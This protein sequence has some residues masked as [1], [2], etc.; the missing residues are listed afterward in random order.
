MGC[1]MTPYEEKLKDLQNQIKS[2]DESFSHLGKIS[3]L[4]KKYEKSK[5]KTIK[6]NL[7]NFK[8]LMDEL[9]KKSNEALQTFSIYNK[10]LKQK[11]EQEE[12]ENIKKTYN[13]KSNALITEL[14]TNKKELMNSKLLIEYP[15]FK[16]ND[17]TKQSIGNSQISDAISYLNHS[18]SISDI[19]LEIKNSIYVNRIDYAS[20][21]I[22]TIL[23]RPEDLS[24]QKAMELREKVIELRYELYDASEHKEIETSLEDHELLIQ[25]VE[26][27]SEAVKEG[28]FYYLPKSIVEDYSQEMIDKN[29]DVINHNMTNYWT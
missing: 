4:F 28:Y 9:R 15:L 18:H 19:I 23:S 25:E 10:D 26:E 1:F 11:K 2:L 13:Q 5:M 29:I 24:N 20:Q 16:D 22:N 3:D 27:F 12:T 7:E 14:K 17:I 21:L 6:N 8:S